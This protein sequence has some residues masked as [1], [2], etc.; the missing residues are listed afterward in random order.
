MNVFCDYIGHADL[1]YSMHALF[2]ERLGAQIFR[3]TAACWQEILKR[4]KDFPGHAPLPPKP[5]EIVVPH[6]MPQHS[7]PDRRNRPWCTDDEG[8][9]SMKVPTHGY[10]QRF[11]SFEQFMALEF[12]LLLTT[13]WGNES[14]F[15]WLSRNLSPGSKLVR[16]IANIHEHPKM[17]KNVMLATDEPMDPDVNA[18]QYYPEHPPSYCAV[19]PVRNMT[20][21]SFLNNVNIYPDMVSHWTHLQKQLPDYQFKQYGM[22]CTDGSIPQIQLPQA[23]Q[24]S[25]FVWHSKPH[26]CCGYVAREALACG[27]PII[28]NKAYTQHHNTLAKR[29]LVDGVNLIDIDPQV[30]GIRQAAEI[31]REWSK[32]N[33]YEMRCRVIK[34]HYQKTINFEREA[35][36]VRAWLA[37]VPAGG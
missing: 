32:P 9:L 31:V 36:S 21:N 35:Q 13:Y 18:L 7:I 25:M 3:P 26:G 29:Y 10:W 11:I 5:G 15:L 30:R 17:I 14:T 2:E 1:D 33:V 12:D 19:E 20:I 8:Y 37:K 22:N 6:Y 23:M 27:K 4:A 28:A 34:D 16:Q 24:D